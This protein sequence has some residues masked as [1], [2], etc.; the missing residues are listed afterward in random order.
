M[1]VQYH[2]EHGPEDHSTGH[3]ND[4]LPCEIERPATGPGSRPNT[5]CSRG[6]SKKTGCRAHYS[7]APLLDDPTI[8]RIT[9]YESEHLNSSGELCHGPGSANA[10]G[11]QGA[12]S[13]FSEGLRQWVRGM[14]LIR[15]TAMTDKWVIDENKKCI[16][17]QSDFKGTDQEF[18]ED[19]RINNPQAFKDWMLN[20]QDVR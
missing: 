18:V 15:G 11:Q 13:R 6:D 5:K 9:I 4:P 10:L 1:Q 7:T 2:C 8:T 19:L 20:A 14:L 12:F 16:R 17:S 3:E